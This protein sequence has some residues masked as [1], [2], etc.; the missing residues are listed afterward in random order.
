[1][2]SPLRMGNS[3]GREE[4]GT[5]ILGLWV[6]YA[7]IRYVASTSTD[8]KKVTWLSTK[9]TFSFLDGIQVF[10]FFTPSERTFLSN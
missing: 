10:D 6:R 1:M 7:S 9:S 2:T 8:S 5:I 4:S 3:L